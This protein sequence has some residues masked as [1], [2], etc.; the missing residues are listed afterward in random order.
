MNAITAAVRNRKI[1]C[2]SGRASM[3]A[4]RNTTGSPTSWTQRGIRIVAPEGSLMR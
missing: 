3:N 1:T 2:P 4:T